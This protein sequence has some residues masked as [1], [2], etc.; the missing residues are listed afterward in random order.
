M[1]K[2]QKF[3]DFLLIGNEFLGGNGLMGANGV[4]I[5]KEEFLTNSL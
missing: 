2:I 1:A 5:P 3:K 4:I